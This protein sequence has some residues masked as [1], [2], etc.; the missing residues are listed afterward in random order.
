MSKRRATKVS[1][2]FSIVSL[3]PHLLIS[4]TSM[5]FTVKPEKSGFGVQ[6]G[7]TSKAFVLQ[8][9]MLGKE[10]ASPGGLKEQFSQK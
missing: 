8:E 5:S 3:L 4:D 2:D 7:W 9:S 1:S 6:I 10:A